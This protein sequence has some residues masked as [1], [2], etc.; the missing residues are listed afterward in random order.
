MKRKEWILVSFCLV[1]IMLVHVIIK[2]GRVEAEEP[3]LQPIE[4]QRK[5]EELHRTPRFLT[6][7]KGEQT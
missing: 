3:S 1:L 6:A 7:T 5:S 4:T 2:A